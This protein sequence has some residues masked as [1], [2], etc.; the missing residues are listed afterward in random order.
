MTHAA[1]PQTTPERSTHEEIVGVTW[2]GLVAGLIAYATVAILVG[3]IDVA[4]GRS[5]FFTPSLLG[6]SL[7]Y[8]L[9]DPAQVVVTPGHVLAYNGL[10]LLACLTIGTAAAWLADM[11]EHGPELWYVS[12]ILFLGVVAAALGGV[13][14]LTRGVREAMPVWIVVVPTLAGLGAMVLY[15]LRARPALRRELTTWRD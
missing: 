4:A 13:L 1:H 14:L 12:T 9:T 5:L 3:A 7:F 6:Q 11:A 2:Q 8:G 10:H 15:I